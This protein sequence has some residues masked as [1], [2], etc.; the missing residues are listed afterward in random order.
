M[1]SKNYWSRKFHLEK[2]RSFKSVSTDHSVVY[3]TFWNSIKI[4]KGPN[5]SLIF[6]ATFNGQ[7]NW[8]LKKQADL[9]NDN[10]R[11]SRPE[12]FSQKGICEILENTSVS[13]YHIYVIWLQAA[14][15]LWKRLRRQSTS[16]FL[17]IFLIFQ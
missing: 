9:V 13:P 7:L 15:L 12:L 11:S 4:T 8:L 2:K 3:C 16:V 10:C 1:T 6:N 5:Y 17:W 14:T